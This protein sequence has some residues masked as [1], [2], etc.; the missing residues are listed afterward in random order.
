MTVNLSLPQVTRIPI[1]GPEP[2][3]TLVCVSVESEI[4]PQDVRVGKLSRYCTRVPT[5]FRLMG[6]DQRLRPIFDH[7]TTVWIN[8]VGPFEDSRWL[9]AVDSIAETNFSSYDG[10][11]YIDVN[12][13]IS[14]GDPAPGTCITYGEVTTVSSDGTSITSSV[15]QQCY[16]FATLQATSWVLCHEPPVLPQPQGHARRFNES[17]SRREFLTDSTRRRTSSTGQST[18]TAAT[19]RINQLL[20]QRLGMPISLRGA[21][22]TSNPAVQ[23]GTPALTSGCACSKGKKRGTT[24][25]APPAERGQTGNEGG[26]SSTGS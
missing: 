6:F 7:S 23:L 13:A 3:N 8:S 12:V 16:Y 20:V 25:P 17:L 18:R 5:P 22:I 26:K 19:D 24:F 15:L 21:D 9:L 1:T 11:Y 2:Y 14:P 10:T 4:G